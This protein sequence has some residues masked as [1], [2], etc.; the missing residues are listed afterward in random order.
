MPGIS[1]SRGRP[2]GRPMGG[3]SQ[4]DRHKANLLQYL[5]SNQWHQ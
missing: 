2:S 5:L 4:V 1:G 3:R